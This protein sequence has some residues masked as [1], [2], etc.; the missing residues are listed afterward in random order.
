[1]ANFDD[2]FLQ[3]YMQGNAERAA[4]QQA[5]RQFAWQN[6]WTQ[7]KLA[8][9]AQQEQARLAQQTAY[10][11]ALIQDTQARQSA[12]EAKDVLEA[13]RNGAVPAQ[14]MQTA[15]PLAGVDAQPALPLP[16]T[17]Q[18]AGLQLPPAGAVMLGGQMLR[19]QS[20]AELTAQQAALADQQVAAGQQRLDKLRDAGLL[21][22][23]QH[24]QFS[25]LNTIHSVMQNADASTIQNILAPKPP[26]IKEGDEPLTD[27]EIAQHNELAKQ[28][29]AVNKV[30]TDAAMLKKGATREQRA[31]AIQQLGQLNSAAATAAGR[32]ATAGQNAI[33]NELRR[34]QLEI[35]QS[36]ETDRQATEA[37]KIIGPARDAL[38][39]A[40]DYLASGHYTGAGDE[41]LQER[42]FDAIKPSQGFRMTKAMMDL[43]A[44]LQSF[45]NRGQAFL[46]N[47]TGG[48]LYS[49]QLRKDVV[50]QIEAAHKMKAEGL[51][52]KGKPAPTPA[53]T[54]PSDK[55][56]LGIR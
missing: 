6:L 2:A 16:N 33:A 19:Q 46:A 36:R 27:D 54:A 12:A 29:G 55:D 24:R 1:M 44:R 4:A 40:H 53:A 52:S 26:A 11:N 50:Q 31:A 51:K 20:P 48:T 41:Q 28:V 10:Q 15:A 23:D 37:E 18:R 22:P 42:F 13:Q 34:Q 39:F 8:Q 43:N 25:A 45:Q 56:P 32:E 17:L 21:T 35:N 38:E 5:A 9:D 49:D 14:P 30:N 47:L 7:A 3:T